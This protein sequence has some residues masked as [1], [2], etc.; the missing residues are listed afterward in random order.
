MTGRPYSCHGDV[1][2]PPDLI[3][4]AIPSAIYIT[5]QISAICIFY[6]FCHSLYCSTY[7]YYYYCYLL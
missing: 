4:L 7:Y 5:V 6:I 3:L 2:H 1:V